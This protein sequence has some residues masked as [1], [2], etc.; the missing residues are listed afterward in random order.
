MLRQKINRKTP[1]NNRIVQVT[2]GVVKGNKAFHS[3]QGANLKIK[4]NSTNTK[5]KVIA[6][7]GRK[8]TTIVRW[9]HPHIGHEY[10]HI[11]ISPAVSG[12]PDP[13]I[14]LS[15]TAAKVFNFLI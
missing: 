5:F 1:K 2:D 9:D 11:N 14:R 6:L 7:S 10:P 12:R 13:H 15:P 8:P 3:T 4:F